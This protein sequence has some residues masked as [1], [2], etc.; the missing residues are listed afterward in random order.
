MVSFV[1]GKKYIVVFEGVFYGWI[2]VV[3]NVIDND[4]IKVLINVIFLVFFL[5]MNDL[6]V[7]EQ[8]LEQGDVVVVIVEG[9][10]GI[11]GIYVFD[12]VF[13]EGVVVFCKKYDVCL[14]FDEI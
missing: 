6:V 8:V 4:K 5:L 12:L 10:Q 3:V 13:L 11:V 9:I 1:I 14:I 2:F 7:V